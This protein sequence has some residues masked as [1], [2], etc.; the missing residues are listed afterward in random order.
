M[1]PNIQSIVSDFTEKLCAHHYA[2]STVKTYKNALIK[3]LNAFKDYE[4]EQISIL[5]VRSYIRHL[6]IQEDISVAYQKQILAT[7]DKF[8]VFYFKQ[9]LNLSSLYPKRKSE[10]PPNYLTALEVRSLLS[11]C[12][13]LK[14]LCVLKILNGCGLRVS[15]VISLVLKDIDPKAMRLIIRSPKD[16]KYRTVPLPKSLFQ[17]LRKYY[18]AYGPKYYLFEGQKTEKYAVKSIQNFIKKYARAATIQKN[19]TPYVLRHS[20][21][22]HQIEKGIDIRYVQYFLGHHSLK[23]TERYTRFTNLLKH[24]MANPLDSL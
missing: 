20:Y 11:H 14:H 15:E 17:S 8:Y 9:K 18:S 16:Q 4:L 2:P 19:V 24:G 3:F 21:A 6:Q 22:I 7:I 1:C 5:H 23:T 10:S 12:N 13:N